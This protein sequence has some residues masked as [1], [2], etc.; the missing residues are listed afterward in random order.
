M[1]VG[2][3][4]GWVVK[5]L[6]AIAIFLLLVVTYGI[7]YTRGQSTALSSW[8]LAIVLILEIIF[9][10]FDISWELGRYLNL[11]YS[12]IGG[13]Y[14]PLGDIKILAPILL[15]VFQQFFLSALTVH[16][17]NGFQ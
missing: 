2:A 11:E 12:Y 17:Q 3:V 1:V 6:L 13:Q 14:I 9:I 5:S 16:I 10:L 8:I 4:W 15:L 7:Y